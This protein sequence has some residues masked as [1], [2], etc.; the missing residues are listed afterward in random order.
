MFNLI[1]SKI[2]DCIELIP[3]IK[4]DNRGRFIKIFSS[5]IFFEFGLETNFVEDY[6]S[7]SFFGVLRGMHFQLPPFDHNK[8]VYC[9]E[10]EVFDAVIDL[11]IGSPTYGI[12]SNLILSANLGNCLYVPKGL[13]HGFCVMSKTATIIYK[14]SSPYS[15]SHDTGIHWNSSDINWPI[16]NPIISDRDMC[17]P[18]MSTFLS[19][20]KWP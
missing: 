5:K 14:V 4:N 15:F 7:N 11:R 13:A 9:V 12:S 17:F 20:F 19:P 18:P 6:Y 10:G 1:P 8:L 2:Q 16:E 3:D